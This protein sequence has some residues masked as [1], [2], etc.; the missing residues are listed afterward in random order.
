MSAQEVPAMKSPI[1]ERPAPTPE[2]E[3]RRKKR[4]R[5]CDV[6]DRGPRPRRDPASPEL[7]HD[8]EDV[9]RQELGPRA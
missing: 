8:P 9:P 6:E 1:E 2:S 4:R 7:P 5:S 3:R